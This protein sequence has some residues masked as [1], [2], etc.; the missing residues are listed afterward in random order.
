MRDGFRII[1]CDRHVM[2]PADMWERYLDRP[3]RHYV[4]WLVQATDTIGARIND[5]TWRGA[6]SY[7]IARG[8][9]SQAYLDDLDREGIDVVVLF[10]TAGLGFCWYDD[11]DP[12]FSAALCR[13]YNNWLY[14]YCSI[15][16]DRLFG[17]ML[18]PLQDVELAEKEL[19][20]ATTSVCLCVRS[21]RT[22][23]AGGGGGDGGACR[24]VGELVSAAGHPALLPP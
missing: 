15:A 23:V 6:F 13:A 5:A 7:A 18:L 4:G 17:M 3:F 22:D 19:R 10:S 9:D 1:D 11:L 16:P 21:T 2:E 24:S 14:D 20:R 8:F 12:E